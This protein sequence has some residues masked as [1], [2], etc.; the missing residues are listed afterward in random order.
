MRYGPASKFF[1]TFSIPPTLKKPSAIFRG[2]EREELENGYCYAGV[3]QFR[4]VEDKSIPPP[5]GMV[6][7]VYVNSLFQVFEWRWEKMEPTEW[8]HPKDFLTRFAEKLWPH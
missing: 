3:P 7:A 4:R 1:E 2:L 6:F 5:D 8:G